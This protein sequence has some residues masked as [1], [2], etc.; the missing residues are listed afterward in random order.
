MKA[1]NYPICV[2]CHGIARPHILMFGDG[3]YAGH[4]GQETNFRKF[5]Q[6]DVDLVFL[7]GSSG[8]VPTNDYIALELK[9]RG[10]NIININPDP[11]T[12]DIAQSETFILLKSRETFIQINDLINNT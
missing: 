3:E 5:I 6:K 2:K 12:N 11:S 8:S 7:V 4:P 9:N 1:S 10:A